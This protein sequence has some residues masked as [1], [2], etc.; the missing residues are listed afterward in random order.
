[1][2]M[3]RTWKVSAGEVK[4]GGMLPDTPRLALPLR[5]SLFYITHDFYHYDLMTILKV[6]HTPL[7]GAQQKGFQ[8]GPALAMAGPVHGAVFDCFMCPNLFRLKSWKNALTVL[9]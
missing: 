4:L 6:L 1:M 5:A 9:F 8:P 2:S 3:E 7:N